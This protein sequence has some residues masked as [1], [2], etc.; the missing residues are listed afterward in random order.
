MVLYTA[1]GRIRIT[2]GDDDNAKPDTIWAQFT[3][4]PP[5]RIEM[6]IL[7]PPEHRIAGQP[8]D[9]I[10]KLYNQD[11][12]LALR[13]SPISISDELGSEIK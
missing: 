4:G 1:S 7:T 6:E 8:I 9:V 10:V 11:N 12:N 3:P 13:R 5:T 2:V